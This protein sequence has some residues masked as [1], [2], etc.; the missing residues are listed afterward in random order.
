MDLYN[1]TIG[2]HYWLEHYWQWKFVSGFQKL[3][4]KQM[5]KFK[6]NCQMC[7]RTPEHIY[8][9]SVVR[10]EENIYDESINSVFH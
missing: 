3:V 5:N 10:T 6:I 7:V 1:N 9:E 8:N 2:P 4:K